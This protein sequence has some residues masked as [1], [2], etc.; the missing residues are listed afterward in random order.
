MI[1][2]SVSHAWMWKED[3]L[4]AHNAMKVTKVAMQATGT[5]GN[6]VAMKIAKQQM[7]CTV[8][9]KATMGT[10]GKTKTKKAAK[11]H[12][13]K[14]GCDQGREA[15]YEGYS[16]QEGDREHGRQNEDKDCDKR[17]WSA[18]RSRSRS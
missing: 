3:W 2:Q 13:R 7:R 11:G 8:G 16:R 12:G 6:T 5:A 4:R 1:D 9:K 17:A 18:R 15:A 14:D 10:D